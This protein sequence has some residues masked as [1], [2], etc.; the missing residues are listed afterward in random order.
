[1]LVPLAAQT[2]ALGGRDPVQLCRGQDRQGLAEFTQ[3]HGGH[4]YR[5]ASADTL[6]TFRSDPDR[7]AIQFGG[8]CARM[9]PLSG[10]GDPQRFLVHRERIYVFASDGC[11]T[12]FQKRA[13]AFLDTTTP[14]PT[15]D[16]QAKATAAAWITRA[17]LSHGGKERLQAMRS[18]RHDL[19]QSVD[20]STTLT[21][22]RVQWPLRLRIDVDYVYDGKT[23]RYSR[24]VGP[25][26]AFFDDKGTLR[27]MAPDARAEA[28]RDL[29][30]EPLVALRA[31]LDG[32][33]VAMPAGTRE[34]LGHKIDELAV[35]QHGRTTFLGLGA[36]GRIVTARW[37]GRGPNLTFGPLEVEYT[38]FATVDGIVVPTGLRGSFDGKDAPALVEV[39]RDVTLGQDLDAAPFRRAK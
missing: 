30:H 38:A 17:A 32:D 27:T 15:P 11:R 39:R 31:L 21:H 7:W 8:A 18:Y 26:D 25:D 36:D 5:F 37:H 10:M 29:A 22:V 3:S 4:D 6:A 1:M 12:T 33:A 34:V 24:V 28:Q 20:G 35:W 19:V 9:G 14:A 13:D 16:A 23:A 2:P